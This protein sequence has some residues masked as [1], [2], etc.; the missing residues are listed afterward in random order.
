M[1]IFTNEA[2]FTEQI[3][4]ARR[5][6]GIGIALIA[7]YALSY[8]SYLFIPTAVTS[9]LIFV[10]LIACM[11]GIPLWRTS[12][13][14]LKRLRVTPRADHLLN[15]EL[16]GLNNKYTLHHYVHADGGVIKHLL[17]T[18]TG[19]VVMESRDEVGP[20][21]CTGSDKGDRWK[22]PGGLLGRFTGAGAVDKYASANPSHDLEVAMS[23]ADGLLTT[24]G[25]PKVP[26]SGF[27]VF[28]KQEDI[29]LEGCSRRAI[30]L[31]ETK[32]LV[33]TIVMESESDRESASDV[34]QLLT[35]ED[36]RRLNVMLAPK[37][38]TAPVKAASTQR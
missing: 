22:L 17:V 31:N 20:V 10:G 5:R 24:V 18:P 30:P 16:K 11:S 32:A 6:Q 27:I 8:G 36:R 26:I 35:S 9:L 19:L 23:R 29:E 15:N 37:Q 28:T 21:G 25:K 34:A 3:Q 1:N 2:F 13:T 33:R 12:A 14:K 38:P 4:A 7:V